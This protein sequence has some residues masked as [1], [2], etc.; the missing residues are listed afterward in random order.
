MQNQRSNLVVLLLVVLLTVLQSLLPCLV[1]AQSLRNE[2]TRILVKLQSQ[3]AIQRELQQWSNQAASKTTSQSGNAGQFLTTGIICD[4]KAVIQS[5]SSPMLTKAYNNGFARLQQLCPPTVGSPEHQEKSGLERIYVAECREGISVNEALEKLKTSGLLHEAFEYAEP[6]YIGCGAGAECSLSDDPNKSAQL[7]SLIPN[8]QFFSSQWG[9]RNVGQTIGGNVGNVGAD[10]NLAPAW[11]ITQ[12][13]ETMIL[14]IL[15]SGQPTNV[16]SM[17]DFFGRLMQGYDFVN[18]DNDPTDDHGHGSNVMSIATAKGNNSA[19]IAGVDWRCR[20]MSVKIL[21]SRNSGQYSWWISGVRFAVDMGAKVL[22]MSVGGSGRSNALEDAI[23]YAHSKGAIIVACMMNTNNN[24]PYYPAAYTETIAVGATNNRD[25]RAVPFCFSATS[26]SN[27][28]A[29]LD[30][31]AP[32]ELIAGYRNTDGA[33]TTWCGTSQATPIV[34]GIVSLMLAVQPRLT[35]EQVRTILRSTATD[36]IGPL[37]E[38]T[39]GWDEYFGAGRVNAEAALQAALRTTSVGNTVE[40]GTRI[41]AVYPQPA[42]SETTFLLSLRQTSHVKITLHTMLG[43]EIATIADKILVAGQH[44][45]FWNC[46]D[47]PSG[48]YAYRLEIDGAVRS[49]FVNVVR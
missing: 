39:Q 37:T 35:F 48:V 31:V 8:D 34:S 6:D 38:D 17:P 19:G 16:A 9:L 33:V 27:Y 5:A 7:Q 29:H 2:P 45:V 26:G 13:S 49:G 46:Q 28:G 32:G 15:D 3:S 36:R 11:S 41:D 25:L 20:I 22:N 44:S 14:A 18:N 40:N 24:V 43:R 42:T 4:I 21:D 47:T 30:V 1:L 12:G 23:K 10:A